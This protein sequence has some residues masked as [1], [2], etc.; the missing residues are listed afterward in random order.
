MLIYKDIIS[1]DE[2][3]SDA[4]NM[5][6][7]ND[8]VYEVDCKMITVRKGADV[9]IGA[10]A[11]TQEAAEALDDGQEE[12]IDVVHSFRLTQTGFNRASYITY[13]RG[14]VAK[15]MEKLAERGASPA[16]IERIKARAQGFA[17]S[18]L[19]GA[20]FKGCDFYMGES[21][22]VDGMVVLLNFRDAGNPYMAFLKDGLEEVKV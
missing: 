6:L 4:F 17:S 3:I 7:I 18:Y 13:F 16:E 10:N 14:Y 5:T 1:G 12:V 2:M 15:L 21:M 22:D 11:S 19:T 8:I 9:D 20:R